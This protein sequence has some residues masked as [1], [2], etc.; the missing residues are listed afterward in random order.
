LDCGACDDGAAC[1]ASPGC[2]FV[3]QTRCVCACDGLWFYA[4]VVD[5][6]QQRGG[7]GAEYGVVF[8]V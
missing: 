1:D 5:C 3:A 7:H 8:F 6:A 4:A 2:V